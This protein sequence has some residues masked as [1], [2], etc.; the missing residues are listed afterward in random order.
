[1]KNDFWILVQKVWRKTIDENEMIEIN[2][3]VNETIKDTI[4]VKIINPYNKNPLFDE[5][6]DFDDEED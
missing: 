1:M 6:G 5:D 3:S 4:S 2:N